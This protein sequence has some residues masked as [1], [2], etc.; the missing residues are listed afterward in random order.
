MPEL[1]QVNILT[2]SASLLQWVIRNYRYGVMKKHTV[3]VLMKLA[4]NCSSTKR[5]I[6]IKQI[7]IIATY[8]SSVSC[9]TASYVIG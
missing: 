4:G 5:E 6:N 3:K 1:T 8:M 9:D 7:I 2:K